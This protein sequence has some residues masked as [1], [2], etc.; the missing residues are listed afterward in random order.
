MPVE[1]FIRFQGKCYDV[2]TR[3]RFCLIKIG[4]FVE[5]FDGTIMWISHNHFGVRL[6]DG[7]EISMSKT[8]PLENYIVE[9]LYPIYYEEPK[10]EYVRGL[11]LRG[12]GACPPEGEIF[13]GW[14]W[15]ISIMVVGSI[16]KDALLIWVFASAV[17]FLWKNGF[18][19]GGNK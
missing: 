5:Q 6:S 18:L 11:R 3:I 10:M 7:R 14:I 8:R 16:F 13:I 15:Y 4:P 1:Y 2:G 9:I 12:G 19:N 17:F